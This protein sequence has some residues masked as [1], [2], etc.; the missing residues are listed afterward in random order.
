MRQTIGIEEFPVATDKS[1]VIRA[2]SSGSGALRLSATALYRK[3]TL[4][5]GP[6]L[7]TVTASDSHPSGVPSDM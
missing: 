3:P 7:S 6:A 1:S 5:K 2:A 4:V